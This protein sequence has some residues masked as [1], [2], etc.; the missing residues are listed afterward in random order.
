MSAIHEIQEINVGL[1]GLGVVGG[2]V[3]ATLLDQSLG[4]SKNVGL[5]VNL[6]K[7]LVRDSNKSRDSSVPAGLI[8]TNPADILADPSI[9]IVVEVIGGTE[10]AA[11]YLKD[12]LYCGKHVV[13][14]NKE[15]MAKFGPELLDLAR[16]NGG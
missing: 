1:L 9:H 11:Q 4:I 8:T 10:P 12:A 14:A 15:A 7:V 2:G 16:Q 6:K 13:T 3:A 5:P